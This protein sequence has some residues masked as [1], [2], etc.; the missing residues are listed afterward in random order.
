MDLPD[1]VS[2]GP[3]R[4][5]RPLPPVL[6]VEGDWEGGA[7][8]REIPSPV[9]IFL[10][11]TY[12]DVMLWLLLPLDRI[13]RAFRVGAGDE[14]RRMLSGIA[15]SPELHRHLVT[16][17]RMSDGE[18]ERSEVGAACGQVAAWANAG[19]APHT[20]LAY[21]QAGALAEPEF[22][23]RSL[24]MG[25]LARDLAQY[26]RAET[27]FKRTIKLARI[28]KDRANYVDAHLGLGTLFNRIGNGPAAKA[29]YER[30]L[31]SA[32]RWRLRHLAGAAHHDLFHMCV[33][34][35]DLRR[36]YDHARSAQ[37]HYG[38]A[39]QY[40]TRLA[41][42]IATVWLRLGEG[43][44]AFPIF[45]AVIPLVPDPGL[46]AVWSA[47]L[48]RCAAISGRGMIYEAVRQ[49]A[50]TAMVDLPISW[51]RAEAEAI[52]AH[53]D[54][55]VGEWDRAAASAEKALELASRI[56]AAELKMYAERALVDAR[57]QRQAKD[58]DVV[59]PPAL[60]RM[61]DSLAS[62]L[63]EAVLPG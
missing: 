38:T 41:G 1:H 5:Y 20:E 13:H 36:A 46:R 45:E 9:G 23:E 10:F 6:R 8:I 58:T 43:R 63:R 22:I 49:R 55:S 17:V 3:S 60:A 33:D 7:I 30:A 57:G 37:Q 53:A 44:R 40:L 50:L 24:R 18:I 52:L 34:L 29:L 35:G 56:G 48:A 39:Q 59:E 47:Q 11:G 42:D 32:R 21:M 31:K 51:R 2:T 16:L 27:W 26:S 12:R 62:A 4:S 14:R 61:A 25:Q 19:G 54:L 28:A 15:A